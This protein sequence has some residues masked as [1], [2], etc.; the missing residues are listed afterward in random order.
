MERRAAF[1]FAPSSCLVTPAVESCARGSKP[2]ILFFFGIEVIEELVLVD[3]ITVAFVRFDGLA[4]LGELPSTL[5]AE[6]G[7]PATI[8]SPISLLHL[9]SLAAHRC[10]SQLTTECGYNMQHWLPHTPVLRICRVGRKASSWRVA[11]KSKSSSIFSSFPIF[12]LLKRHLRGLFY[13][14]KRSI[15]IFKN[16]EMPIFVKMGVQSDVA[17][18]HDSP[19]Q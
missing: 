17:Y 14:P 10:C 5:R 1:T 19:T 9:L 13:Q 16:H 18:Y 8:H 11:P 4:G 6:A 7:F 15:E 2:G 3:P 12:L